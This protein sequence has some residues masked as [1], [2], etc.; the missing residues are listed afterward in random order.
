MKPNPYLLAVGLAVPTIGACLLLGSSLARDALSLLLAVICA[1]YV[2]YG[3]ADG[4]PRAVITEVSVAAVFFAFALLGLRA[5]SLWLVVGYV[6]HGVWDY[7]HRPKLVPTRLPVWY[8]PFCAVYD[9]LI[10]AFIV[11]DIKW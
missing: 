4:S 10:A 6:L 11:I 5:S 7:L 2:G 3:L 9:W 1:V 8:P